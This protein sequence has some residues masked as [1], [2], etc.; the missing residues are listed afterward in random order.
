MKI[1]KGQIVNFTGYLW[2]YS[3]YQ[4]YALCLK[5]CSLIELAFLYKKYSG[6]VFPNDDDR[7]W[8][9]FWEQE[10]FVRLPAIRCDWQDDI[11]KGYEKAEEEM[12]EVKQKL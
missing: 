6:D 3:G 11:V 8:K 2:H 5:D 7:F 10:Y 12:K 9:W 4:M 1:K